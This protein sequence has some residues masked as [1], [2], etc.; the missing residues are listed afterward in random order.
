MFYGQDCA[1][2][3]ID[4]Y[5]GTARFHLYPY[6]ELFFIE[7]DYEPF[8]GAGRYLVFDE[9][10]F[11]PEWNNW[12][13]DIYFDIDDFGIYYL[14]YD[15]YFDDEYSY[16]TEGYMWMET[17]DDWYEVYL[18]EEG[19]SMWRDW[20]IGC[21]ESDF[22]YDGSY[23][24]WV[25]GE[26]GYTGYES[27]FEMHG[28]DC[29]SYYYCNEAYGCWSIFYHPWED[30]FYYDFTDTFG[31]DPEFEGQLINGFDWWWFDEAN[32]YIEFDMYFDPPVHGMYAIWFGV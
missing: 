29:V 7:M 11:E 22:F 1:T 18:N 25:N 3:W 13:G 23:D 17:Y 21:W 27:D 28:Y 10:W 15:F 5:E 8:P 9:W 19:V 26:W 31:E 2:F 14:S 32:Q 16:M 6:E 24:K 30:E 20:A 12:W 4:S